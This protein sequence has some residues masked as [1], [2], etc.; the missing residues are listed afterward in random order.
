[1]LCS[2]N[3][4]G[5]SR[6]ESQ[7]MLFNVFK[8]QLPQVIKFLQSKAARYLT[9]MITGFIA[10]KITP[11]FGP[12]LTPIITTAIS[13]PVTEASS[14]FIK[15]I[16]DRFEKYM[17][18]ENEILAVPYIANPIVN[19]TRAVIPPEAIPNLGANI[20]VNNVVHVNDESLL[21]IFQVI[22]NMPSSQSPGLQQS[23]H[24]SRRRGR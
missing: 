16:F 14:S 23:M 13:I 2:L 22:K 10:G 19:I 6:G 11:M 12:N 24:A 1:V 18:L 21:P 4:P 5:F 9:G 20:R 17:E 3:P 7:D 15:K 8:K